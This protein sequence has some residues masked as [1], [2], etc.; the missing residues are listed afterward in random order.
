[1][2]F[3]RTLAVL[4]FIALSMLAQIQTVVDLHPAHQSQPHIGHNPDRTTR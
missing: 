1:M 4:A 2:R 3:P